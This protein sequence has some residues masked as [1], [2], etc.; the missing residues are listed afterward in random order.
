MY[1]QNA[2][3]EG[4]ISCLSGNE[5]PG[6]FCRWSQPWPTTN[7]LP[8]LISSL[9]LKQCGQ[10]FICSQT[11]HRVQS[12]YLLSVTTRPICRCFSYR[13]NWTRTA[14]K[15]SVLFP[16]VELGG[17]FVLKGTRR[18]CLEIKHKAARS[19]KPATNSFLCKNVLFQNHTPHLK[20]ANEGSCFKLMYL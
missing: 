13:I 9:T 6:N 12:I 11:A 17:W 2:G 8:L 10:A 3:A 14:T 16:S 5:H 19:C 20:A 18:L 15:L 4:S 7:H 1:V